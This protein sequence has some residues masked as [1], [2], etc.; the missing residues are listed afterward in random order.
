MLLRSVA[1]NRRELHGAPAKKGV[2]DLRIEVERVARGARQS[3][4][5]NG[6]THTRK[7]VTSG[8]VAGTT[9]SHAAC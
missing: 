5:T 4:N 8:S 1:I 6:Q 3:A 2:E 7:Q 9:V